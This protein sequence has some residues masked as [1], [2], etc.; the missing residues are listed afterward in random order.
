MEKTLFSNEY[1][2]LLLLLREARE[3]LD[4]TQAEV[5]IRMGT[6]QSVVSKCERGERRLD[7][8]ELRKWCQAI[9]MPLNDFLF[10]FDARLKKLRAKRRS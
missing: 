9:G 10:E 7:V 2:I 8:L 5:A 3:S 4:I 1:K 6:T